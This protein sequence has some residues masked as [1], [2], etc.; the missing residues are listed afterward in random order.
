[1]WMTLAAL[2]AHAGPAGSAIPLFRPFAIPVGWGYVDIESLDVGN[3]GKVDF[4]F[5]HG[6]SFDPPIGSLWL[7]RNLGND[8]FDAPCEL[9]DVVPDLGFGLFAA[10]DIDGGGDDLIARVPKENGEDAQLVGLLQTDGQFEQ[11]TLSLPAACY[12]PVELRLHDIDGDGH[13]DLL[14]S[15]GSDTLLYR[16]P[17]FDLDSTIDAQRFTLGDVDDDGITD[18]VI[19]RFPYW[20]D[21]FV[22]F[23]DGNGPSS[24]KTWTQQRM[25]GIRPLAS[26]VD[27]Q[28]T[29]APAILGEPDSPDVAPGTY[30]F[31]QIESWVF[32]APEL[33]STLEVTAVA[34]VDGDGDTDAFVNSTLHLNEGGEL[35]P[36]T[37]SILWSRDFRD[38]DGDGDLDM[39]P[40]GD[41][42][43]LGAFNVGPDLD[44]DGLGRDEE[45]DRRTD[46]A[47]PDTDGDG[48]LDGEDLCLGDDASGDADGDGF[49]DSAVGGGTCDTD[50]DDRCARPLGYEACDGIDD[51]C[52]GQIDEDCGPVEA[53]PCYELPA[54]TLQT[55]PE[56]TGNGT[57]DT[58]APAEPSPAPASGGCGCTTGATP[59]SVALAWLMGLLALRRR[60]R[61]A[62]PVLGCLALSASA[63]AAPTPEAPPL[64]RSFSLDPAASDYGITPGQPFDLG[65]DGRTDL[66]LL[67]GAFDGPVPHTQIGLVRNL[68]DGQMDETC[69]L[70]DVV[71]LA[72]RSEALAVGD[73]DDDGDHDVLVAVPGTR[74][75]RLFPDVLLLEQQP[76]AFVASTRVPQDCP[77][78]SR[79]ELHDVDG[80][81]Q[82]DLFVTC[83]VEGH[84]DVLLGPAFT[85]ALRLD[86]SI[87]QVV[88]LDTDGSVEVVTSD[89]AGVSVYAH[90]DGELL[91]VA[92]AQPVDGVRPISRF[93]DRDGDGRFDLVGVEAEE[94]LDGGTFVF[95]QL[96]GLQF[97]A[98]V[99]WSAEYLTLF[100]DADGDGDSD[101]FRGSEM[102]LNEDGLLGSAGLVAAPARHLGDL[103]GDGDPDIVPWGEIN[104]QGAWNVGPDLDGDGLGRDE[105]RDRRT[106]ADDPDTDGDGILDGNDDCLGDDASG[107]ADGDGFCESAVGGGAC[108]TDDDDA[109]TRP[110]GFEA[111]D[112][113]DD[114]CD[115]VVD[116]DCGPVEPW[117]CYEVPS[118]EVDGSFGQEEP[119]AASPT[120]DTGSAPTQPPE[121]ITTAQPQSN[122]G[123]TSATPGG[124]ALGLVLLTVLARRRTPRD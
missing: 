14:E 31:P 44:G 67:R 41:G 72:A 7:V 22:E 93:A 61:R 121:D 70:D 55:E 30:L 40:Q 94:P 80:D 104:A 77:L 113:I 51:D 65:N 90:D 91:L 24:T 25:D 69:I 6:R 37:P 29:G 81:E 123:C 35:G 45:R 48:L 75:D 84:V 103:D 118:C 120:G 110:L 21:P 2:T 46:D 71:P 107:D 57:G 9:Q 12:I 100:A 49:C 8:R 76:G 63:A 33:W 42:E 85:T 64:F 98:P 20:S 111:C 117:P 50:D 79:F 112:G 97:S 59:G 26:L 23:V 92:S 38:L 43:L 17:K 68:G 116:E 82:L 73:L 27:R 95:P 96:D 53:W 39:A 10:G 32:G 34:D 18:F 1:M 101:A 15:C 86:V 11:G 3:D 87:Y 122:C 109:C 99:Q 56:P 74:P 52:D 115:G 4:L 114:D 58:A 28:G 54:C 124:A 66:V 119:P 83:G 102:F 108:D 19:H 89:D 78:P 60:T 106:D 88:D 16:G 36:G 47:D 105:E 5:A 62:A 13:L